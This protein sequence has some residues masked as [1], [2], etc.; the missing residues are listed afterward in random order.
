MKVIK[1]ISTQA[2]RG[3]HLTLLYGIHDF[4]IGK[5]L[6]ARTVEGICWLAINCPLKTFRDNWKGAE[7]IE[8]AAATKNIA[9]EIARCWPQHLDQ[10]SIPVVLYGT[11]FQL[12]V[13]H[14]LLK[15]KSGTTVTYEHIAK[16]IGKPT[17]MRA[18]G[19]AVGK[20]PV[21]MIVPCHRVVN[22]SP[23]KINYAWGASVK[24]ALLAQEEND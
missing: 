21:S 9:K 11:E 15:I 19:S 7:L 6:I 5:I 22:K 1:H 14:E 18:V 12:Q 4:P 3:Q 16:K 20:N 23:S 10:L 13:W 17:A 8:D 24:I 2:Q